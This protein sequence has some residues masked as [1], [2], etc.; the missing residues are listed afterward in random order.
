MSDVQH[1]GQEKRQFQEEE[2]SPNMSCRRE[3]VHTCLE[4]ISTFQNLTNT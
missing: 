2:Q 1:G 3:E 4:Q